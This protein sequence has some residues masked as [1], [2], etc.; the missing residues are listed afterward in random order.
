MDTFCFAAKTG[1]HALRFSDCGAN[2]VCRASKAQYE[3]TDNLITNP[4]LGFG[5]SELTAALKQQRPRRDISTLPIVESDPSLHGA[6][7]TPVGSSSPGMMSPFAA[8]ANSPHEHDGTAPAHNC[9]PFSGDAQQHNAESQSHAQQDVDGHAAL[10]QPSPFG[11]EQ[12][13][14]ISA[15]QSNDQQ[16]QDDVCR[17]NVHDEHG[18]QE[19]DLQSN[20]SSDSRQNFRRKGRP[21]CAVM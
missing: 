20:N 10:Q 16:L 8:L 9:T 3:D 7:S 2:A 13:M 12:D 15:Q 11:S 17:A 1:P 14:P 19:A 21:K 18:D 4:S 5:V 6:S